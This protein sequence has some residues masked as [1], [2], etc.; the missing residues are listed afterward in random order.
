[1]VSLPEAAA[2]VIPETVFHIISHIRVAR[3]VVARDLAVVGRAL[4]GVP[5]EEGDGSSG[6]FFLEDAGED[7]YLIAF[8]PGG[9]VAAGP[10]FSPVQKDLNISL[11]EREA[12]RAAIHNH[13]D[14]GTVGFA[15]GGDTENSSIS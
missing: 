10:R 9:R 11:R 2:P 8:L 7:F 4:G 13:A 1:M 12:G 5:H 6:G 14:A 15:P 3:T